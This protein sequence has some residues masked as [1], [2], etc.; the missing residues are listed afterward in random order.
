MAG[1]VA[2][3]GAGGPGRAGLRPDRGQKKTAQTSGGVVFR[4][5]PADT[6]QT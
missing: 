1:G 5:R 2:R 4:P 3:I 6:S